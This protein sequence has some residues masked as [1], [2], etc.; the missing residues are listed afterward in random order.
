MM[1]DFIH[2]KTIVLLGKKGN[3]TSSTGNTILG[4]QEFKQKRSMDTT[5]LTGKVETARCCRTIS[6][7][8]FDFIIVDTPGLFETG[9]VAE[10]ALELLEV[11]DLK[12]HVFALVLRADLFT[13]DE[14]CAANMLRM[15]F[16]ENVF[17][18]DDSTNA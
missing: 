15:I 16:G 1:S 18:H 2:E 9:N 5:V 13:D 11:T 4:R 14:K 7:Y 10:T 17:K 3:G 6:H 12:P 8:E